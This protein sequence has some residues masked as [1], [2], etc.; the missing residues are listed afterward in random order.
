VGFL[1]FG[2]SKAA[3]E[4]LVDKS[5]SL[6]RSGIG[7]PVGISQYLMEEELLDP[8]H[9]ESFSSLLQILE[10]RYRILKNALSKPTQQWTVYPFNAGCF[11]LLELRS[12]LHAEDIRQRLIAEESVGVVNQSDKHIRLAFCSL[13]EEAIEPLV[14][15]LERVCAKSN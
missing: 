2:T 8:R 7:S 9:D 6:I 10:R 4:I 14:E 5:K 3:A 13:K 11:C 12:G 15:A 1:T